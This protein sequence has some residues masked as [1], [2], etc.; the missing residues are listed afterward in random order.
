[1]SGNAAEGQGNQ[2]SPLLEIKLHGI[3]PG[4]EKSPPE[5]EQEPSAFATT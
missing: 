5:R 4:T 3:L 1:M 2:V